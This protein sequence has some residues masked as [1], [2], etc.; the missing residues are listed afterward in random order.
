MGRG[1][2]RAKL[3]GQGFFFA[4]AMTRATRRGEGN[5]GRT[6][7]ERV[8]GGCLWFAPINRSPKVFQESWWGVMLIL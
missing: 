6:R 4:K 1:A 2:A 7:A 8:F 5:V 3:A